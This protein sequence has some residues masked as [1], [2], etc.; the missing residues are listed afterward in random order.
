MIDRMLWW[1]I[2]II[3]II[4]FLHQFDLFCKTF[5]TKIKIRSSKGFKNQNKGCNKSKRDQ[6]SLSYNIAHAIHSLD[7]LR[8][9]GRGERKIIGFVIFG[10]RCEIHHC[11]KNLSHSC[12]LFVFIHCLPFPILCVCVC[13][14]KNRFV[15][16]LAFPM[17]RA[18]SCK[19]VLNPL[20]FFVYILLSMPTKLLKL[21]S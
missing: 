4:N 18:W 1:I 7:F 9:G 15:Y 19:L 12:F 21:V 11:V 13:F 16:S 8:R 14:T 2:I 10:R 5:C 20:R 17:W 6:L 3:I